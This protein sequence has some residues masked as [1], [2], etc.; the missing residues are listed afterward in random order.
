MLF[1]FISFIYSGTIYVL[2][3]KGRLEPPGRYYWEV[4]IEA[5]AGSQELHIGIAEDNFKYAFI[6][7]IIIISSYLCFEIT[8]CNMDNIYLSST[9]KNLKFCKARAIFFV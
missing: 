1:Y 9:Y 6:I 5:M 7:I 4:T 3:T 8:I 2:R